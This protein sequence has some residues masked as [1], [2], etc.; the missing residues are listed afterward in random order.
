MKSSLKY[1]FQSTLDGTLG[2][3]D[4]KLILEKNLP[5]FCDCFTP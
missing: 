2:N 5:M 1:C 3:Y 4:V